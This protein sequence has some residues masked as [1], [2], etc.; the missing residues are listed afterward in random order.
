MNLTM[1]MTAANNQ[2]SEAVAEIVR[3]LKEHE[4]FAIACHVRPDGDA[5]GS[6]LGL[7]LSLLEAGKEVVCINEDGCPDNLTFLPGMEL[8]H[9]SSGHG[10]ILDVDV[11]IALD[12]A[13]RARLGVNTLG[14]LPLEVPWI[15]IDH[16]VS[17]PGYGDINLIDD[18]SPATGQIVYEV[19]KEAGLPMPIRALDNL[20]VAISTDTG[21]FQYPSTGARTF[22][23]ASEMV[24]A[25][26]DVGHLSSMTYDRRPLRK[27][28]LLQRLYQ[29]LELTHDNK[30]A[31]WWLD[32]ETSRELG[33]MPEDSED[34]IND[35]R[36]IDTVVVAVFFEELPDGNIRVSSRSKNRDVDVCKICQRFGGGGHSLAAG[37]R[38]PG[39]MKEAQKQFLQAVYESF[40][41]TLET[42]DGNGN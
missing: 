31:S 36:S 8:V 24:E 4:R 22:A 14:M 1:K 12:T 35:I 23:I 15:N 25:G 20:F 40:D 11:V 2:Q 34:L 28:L 19:L 13:A 10:G 16:H 39:P 18:S 38:M 21:S 9:M 33:L 41:K 29:R 27:V 32:M 5:I 3:M 7:A 26:L 6:Q 30:V 37:A 42:A 17:N